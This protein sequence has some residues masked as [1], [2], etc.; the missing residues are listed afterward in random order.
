V[1]F[2]QIA[3]NLLLNASAAAGRH[4]HL[5]LVVAESQNS[6]VI[7]ARNDG[8]GMSGVALKSLMSDEPV[9]PGGGFGLRVI[10]EL[11]DELGAEIVHD[12]TD[13]MTEVSVTI[14]VRVPA[15]ETV[16]A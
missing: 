16:D 9:Q 2:R 1:Q 3:L 10:R 8:P 6:L 11:A 14:P 12:R 5:G 15:R 7:K 13:G 4:G